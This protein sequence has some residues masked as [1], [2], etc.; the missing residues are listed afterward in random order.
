VSRCDD[1][2][3]LLPALAHRELGAWDR[4]RVERH[5]RGCRRCVEALAETRRLSGA[6]QRLSPLSAPP[7]FDQRMTTALSL[8]LRE[9]D[10]DPVPLPHRRGSGG[11]RLA[12]LAALAASAA[13]V[14]VVTH[15]AS[16]GETFRRTIAPL[17]AARSVH[18]EGRLIHFPSVLSMGRERARNFRVEYWARSPDRYRLRRVPMDRNSGTRSEVVLVNGE[19]SRRVVYGPDGRVEVIPVATSQSAGGSPVARVL[20]GGALLEAALRSS[21]A[22]VRRETVPTSAGARPGMVLEWSQPNLRRRWR[23]AVDPPS[24][25]ITFAEFLAEQFFA[26]AWQ[27]TARE[28]LDRFDYDVPIPEERFALPLASADGRRAGG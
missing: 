13:T 7:G 27:P 23:V 20:P 2:Q 15:R 10:P 9:D 28:E 21:S 12:L 22:R 8:G 4:W 16:P 26:G 1:V 14:S 5:L 24:G 18:A 11:K 6:L 3:A 19:T 25:R 17:D